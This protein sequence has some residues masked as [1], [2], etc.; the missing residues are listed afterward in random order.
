MTRKEYAIIFGAVI[1][2]VTF[3]AFIEATLL[4]SF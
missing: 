3:A 1:A 2:S 4:R